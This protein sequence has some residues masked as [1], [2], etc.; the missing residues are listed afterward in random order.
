M[1]LPRQAR[2]GRATDRIFRQAQRQAELFRDTRPGGSKG[3]K[4]KGF[5]FARQRGDAGLGHLMH[6]YQGDNDPSGLRPF[7]TSYLYG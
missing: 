6:A 7:C 4:D 3:L 1:N 5:S 2:E